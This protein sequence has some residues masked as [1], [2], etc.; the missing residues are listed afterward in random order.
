MFILQLFPLLTHTETCRKTGDKSMNRG[1]G[2]KVAG[3]A[4]NQSEIV[5][6]VTAHRSPSKF[7]GARRTGSHVSS[8][9]SEQMR[10]VPCRDDIKLTGSVLKKAR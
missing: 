9:V 2:R 6:S 8:R 5:K 1:F 3:I 7:L 4:F 10:G